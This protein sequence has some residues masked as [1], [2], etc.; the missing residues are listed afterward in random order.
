MPVAP[1]KL[2]P[3]VVMDVHQSLGR[4][5]ERQRPLWVDLL[6]YSIHHL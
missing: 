1:V 5:W 6:K 4:W 2:V 3:V